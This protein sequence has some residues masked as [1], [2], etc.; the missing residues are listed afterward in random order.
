MAEQAPPKGPQMETNTSGRPINEP[1]VYEHPQAVNAD[2]SHK[3][4][5]VLPDGKSTAVQDAAVRMGFVKVADAPSRVEVQAMQDAQLAKDLAAE[6]AGKATGVNTDEAPATPINGTATAPGVP[7][8]DHAAA[9]ARA[10]A[11]E[12]EL[13]KLKAKKA[14][15]KAAAEEKPAEE[16]PAEEAPAEEA[17]A[18][19]APADETKTNDSEGN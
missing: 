2:G 19:E 12:A 18:E 3:Q 9:V 10:E 17:P 4:I 8:E 7:A 16:Q 14:P 11:A 1:G 15:A 5:I 13:A 6:K